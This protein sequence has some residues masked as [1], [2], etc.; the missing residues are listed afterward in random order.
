MQDKTT[1]KYKKVILGI[2]LL[3]MLTAIGLIVFINAKSQETTKTETPAQ[4]VT[5]PVTSVKYT[6]VKGESILTQLK[7]KADVVTK[8]SSY[9]AFVDSINGL[10]GG[11][12]G[13][14][15]VFYVNGKMADKGA[16]SYV[17]NG[18]EVVEWKFE[19]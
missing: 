13:K 5:Q 16:D 14:Y 15:W 12:D 17:A 9:G 11:T 10:K 19:K 7:T 2:V 3:A 4:I 18:G 8:D 6:A 1:N